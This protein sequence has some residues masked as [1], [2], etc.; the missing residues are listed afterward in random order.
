MT[1]SFYDQPLFWWR[2]PFSEINNVITNSLLLG[3]YSK[4]EHSCDKGVTVHLVGL[5]GCCA[6]L[7][8]WTRTNVQCSSRPCS[9][10]LTSLQVHATSHHWFL[11]Q[12]CWGLEKIIDD[13][14]INSKQ[15]SFFRIWFQQLLEKCTKYK[16][17]GG[18]DFKNKPSFHFFISIQT[19]W[20]SPRNKLY[21][22]QLQKMHL[23][24]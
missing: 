6:L 17:S 22:R 18:N 9:L 11:L 3:L 12:I 1:Q 8:T 24:V 14:I 13:L 21:T 2:S 10:G 16:E 19:L 5:E 7:I 15:S 4:L 23:K 20:K